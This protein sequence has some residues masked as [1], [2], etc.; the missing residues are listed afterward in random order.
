VLRIKVSGISG[1]TDARYCAGMGVEYLSLDF[2]NQ[3]SAVISPENF[4]A[5]RPWIEGIKWM[6]EYAGDSP[7]ILADIQKDYQPDAFLLHQPLEFQPHN[8]EL[9]HRIAFGSG[10]GE[11]IPSGNM[12]LFFENENLPALDKLLEPFSG[13]FSRGCIL[14]NYIPPGHA[15]ELAQKFPDLIFSLN[16]SEEDR[17]GWMD[18]GG[19]QEYL[20]YLDQS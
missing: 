20:E 4:Q 11:K 16:S 15:L 17:P 18:L 19:L 13:A 1:L 3:G 8:A 6:A 14:E 7:E 10:P 9:W 12:Q 2:S 5:I